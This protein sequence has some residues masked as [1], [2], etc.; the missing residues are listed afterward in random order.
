MVF[1]DFFYTLRQAGLKVTLQ[2]WRMLLECL[3]RGLHDSRLEGFYHIARACL[4]K[5][6]SDFDTF[7]LVFA[8]YFEGLEGAIEIPPELLEWLAEPK[9]FEALSEEMRAALEHLD[10]DELM[11]RFAETMAEQT[12]RHDGGSR[13]VGTGGRSPF[14]H[15]GEH[16]TGIRVGGA[17]RGRMAMKVL[18]DREFADYRT[19]VALDVR[20]VK[21]A[22]RRLRQLTRTDGPEELDVDGTIDRTCREAGEIEL[23]FRPKRKNDV[24]LLLLMDVG[25]TMD[26]YY[27]PVSRLLT[28]LHEERGLRDFKAYYFHNCVYERVF[29]TGRLMRKE[30]ILTADLLRTYGERWKLLVVGDAAM[31]PSELES[32]RGNIDPRRETETSGLAWLDRLQRHFDRSVWVNPDRPAEWAMSST[33]RTISSLFPMYPLTVAGLEDA[34]KALVGARAAT[35]RPVIAPGASALG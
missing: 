13:W 2:E 16:P 22:L 31:H 33:C 20:N 32:A 15:G 8:K 18:E 27:E 11:R 4:V 30:S 25:G 24:R 34:V 14:G 9:P 5:S 23:V 17:G 19:D 1:L 21:L 10:I 6:E 12:E 3:E 29:E 7:D 35:V 26:P 28:A